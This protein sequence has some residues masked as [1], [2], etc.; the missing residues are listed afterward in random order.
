[1]KVDNKKI[2]DDLLSDHFH[3]KEGVVKINIGNNYIHE[4]A[5]FLTCWELA[6]DGKRFYT[7]AIFK[8]GKRCDI[9]SIDDLK[10][11]EILYSEKL[12]NPKDYPLQIIKLKAD[13]VIQYW[14]PKVRK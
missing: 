6:F 3:K 11:I 9:I 2:V 7:E 8:N 1:M 4:L 14:I 10:V 5:K 12:E 13:K